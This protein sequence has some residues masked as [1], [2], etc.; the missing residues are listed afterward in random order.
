MDKNQSLFKILLT[1]FKFDF[2]ILVYFFQIADTHGQ[3]PYLST[4]VCPES[5]LNFFLYYS[6][7]VQRKPNTRKT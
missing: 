2:A 7:I 6:K 5:R 1:V 4:R 3:I